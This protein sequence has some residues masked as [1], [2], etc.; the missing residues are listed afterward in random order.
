MF[1]HDALLY[2][3][4]EDFLATVVPFLDDGAERGEAAILAVDPRLSRM[5]LD[6]VRE[7]GAVDVLDHAYEAPLATLRLNRERFGRA[8]RWMRM[9]GQIPHAHVR[10]DWHGWARYEAAVNDCYQPFTVTGMCP[11]DTRTTPD[12]VLDDVLF[13]HPR[14]AGPTGP[15][16]NWDYVEPNAFLALLAEADVDPLERTEPRFVLH[17]PLPDDARESVIALGR[18]AGLGVHDGRSL[19]LA[20]REVVMNAMEHGKP[21]VDVSGW[22]RAGRVAVAV[23]DRGTGLDDP[24][25]GLVSK[26]PSGP[27]QE[28]GLHIAY[29]VC[30]VTMTY[31]SAAFTVHLA[32][33]GGPV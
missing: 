1:L 15:R 11:Y 9:V 27:S 25:S 31:T 17:D 14:I 21:P 22:G 13:T 18:T 6:A 29:S 10:D 3:S 33:G 19:G 24:Y 12:A 23:R 7:P 8:T 16:H 26:H 2:D 30:D 20:T 32:S 5:V 28:L 4:D